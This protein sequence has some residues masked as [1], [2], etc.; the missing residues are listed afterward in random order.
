MC[1]LSLWPC[2]MHNCKATKHLSSFF[3]ILSPYLIGPEWFYLPIQKWVFPSLPASYTQQAHCQSGDPSRSC[4]QHLK[5]V[6]FSFIFVLTCSC[7]LVACP[8]SLGTVRGSCAYSGQGKLQLIE[9]RTT[10]LLLYVDSYFGSLLSFSIF[11]YV[12]TCCHICLFSGLSLLSMSLLVDIWYAERQGHVMKQKSMA[13]S[14]FRALSWQ[15][16]KILKDS[17]ITDLEIMS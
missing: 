2:R 13:Y 14:W 12:A 11:T 3:K 7:R 5:A 16:E 10:Y 6:C 4:L 8:K 1:K 9:E 15:S 17:Q